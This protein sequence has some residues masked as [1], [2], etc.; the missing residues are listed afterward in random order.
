MGFDVKI[1]ADSVSPDNYRLTTMELCYP[2]I[3][4]AEVM[5]HRVF[6]LAGDS[7]L[8]FDL[9]S[10]AKGSKN[11]VHTMRLDDFV[12]KWNHGANR[13]GS[14]PKTKSHGRIDGNKK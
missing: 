8:E 1:L 11:R 13:V 4:H 12:D 5:T 3:I 6:C 2:R 9:P 10:G 14:K 7:I